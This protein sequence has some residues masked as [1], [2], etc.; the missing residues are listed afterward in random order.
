[1]LHHPKVV[2]YEINVTLRCNWDCPYCSM[3]E[4]IG[5]KIDILQ[6]IDLIKSVPKGAELTLS[7]GEPGL[8]PETKLQAILI[9]AMQRKLVLNTNG[10]FIKKYRKYL[11]HFDVINLHIDPEKEW[12][13][14]SFNRVL[15]ATRTNQE[16]L[17]NFCKIKN[18][19]FDIIPSSH[20]DGRINEYTCYSLDNR[21]FEFMTRESLRHYF[22]QDRYRNVVYLN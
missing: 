19:K 18:Q 14:G 6:I 1:M 11:R 3:K 16:E 8:L 9:A 12:I 20:N 4:R 17:L 22:L 2:R 10:L 15:I 5:G 21:L 13:D 7:G